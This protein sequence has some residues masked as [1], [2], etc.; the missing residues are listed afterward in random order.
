MNDQRDDRPWGEMWFGLRIEILQDASKWQTSQSIHFILFF[1]QSSTA[2]LF[3]VFFLLLDAYK[4]R[5][6]VK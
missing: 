4:M 6:G 2:F 1:F 5:S 3:F